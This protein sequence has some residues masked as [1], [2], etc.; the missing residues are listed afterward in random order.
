MHV[1]IVGGGIA[2]LSAAYKLKR[3]S[4]AGVDVSYTIVEKE[5]RVGGQI[6]TDRFPCEAGEVVADGGSDSYLT[7]KGAVARIA[8]ML[9]IADEIVGTNDENKRTFIIRNGKLVEMPD[10][11]MMF[12]PTKLLPLATTKLYSW[13]AKFR[14][15]LDLV[16]PKK[17]LKDGEIEDESL[18]S[19]V[20]RRLGQEALDHL[21]EAI[22]GGVNGSDPKTMSIKA[23][24]PNLLEM[25]QEHGSL[26]RGFLAQ[27]KKVEE[28][29]RKYPPK[30]GAKP[31]TFFSSFK[32]GLGTVTDALAEAV[33]YSNIKLG[34]EVISVHETCDGTYVALLNDESS[35]EADAVILCTPAWIS[36]RILN[37]LSKDSAKL[38]ASI[39]YSSCATIIMCF[40]EED[41]PIDRKWHGALTPAVE[42]RR[43]TGISLI[44]SKWPD[45]TPKGQILLRAFAGGPR[46]PKVLDLCDSEL[47]DLA[48]KEYEELLGLKEDAPIRYAKIF[49]FPHSMPQYTLGHLERVAEL[50]EE[51]GSIKGISVGGAPYHGV[52]VPNCVESGEAAVDKVLA[53]LKLEF[54]EEVQSRGGRP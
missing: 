44:T 7:N 51:L 30:P 12:A 50:E 20:V 22:V 52:G 26:I 28:M 14:M 33:D 5:E 19:L 1:L 54:K 40:D 4:E 43:I 6:W 10:G 34:K 42:D 47:I 35:I 13:P 37:D 48:R 25:E 9:G 49:R 45:R 27:R 23:T 29:R 17:K 3:A 38:L 53:D 41:L 2:G 11:I 31:R 32:Q 15:A 18:E 16:I 21:A 8:S 24:Y 39:P 36:A 46:D